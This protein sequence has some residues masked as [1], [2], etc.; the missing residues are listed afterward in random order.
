MP[1]NG[2]SYSWSQIKIIVDSVPYAEAKAISYTESQEKTLNYGVGS[3]PTSIGN[4]RKNYEG[5]LT[6]SLADVE[7][8]RQ[9][10]PGRSILDLPPLSL[11]VAWTS[12]TG[13]SIIHTLKDVV[14]TENPLTVAEGDTDIPVELS[15]IFADLE[16]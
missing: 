5:S 8:L 15:F 3:K 16:Q 6:M 4:G 7:S 11:I 9:T 2:E 13:L 14:F 12:L 1:I 10:A